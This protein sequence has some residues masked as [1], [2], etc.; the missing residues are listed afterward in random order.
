MLKFEIK[1]ETILLDAEE[2]QEGLKLVQQCAGHL[3]YPRTP[4]EVKVD[5]PYMHVS[6]EGDWRGRECTP[7]NAIALVKETN[8]SCRGDWA[9]PSS[10]MRPE[11]EGWKVVDKHGKV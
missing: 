5:G 11:W 7:A 1:L 2:S 9:P 8:N 3:M 10:R 6:C 4:I